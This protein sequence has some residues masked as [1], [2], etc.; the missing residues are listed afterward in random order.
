MSDVRNQTLHPSPLDFIGSLGGRWL[1]SG[2][3][4]QIVEESVEGPAFSAPETPIS[5]GNMGW[6][7]W[8][9]LNRRPTVYETVALPLS[10]TGITAPEHPLKGSRARRL[11][12]VPA[13]ASQASNHQPPFPHRH[14]RGAGKRGMAAT[15]LG[16]GRSTSLPRWP[17]SDFCLF[18]FN[19]AFAP[20]TGRYALPGE[21]AALSPES[22]G[23]MRQ[24]NGFAGIGYAPATR[25][26]GFNS[27]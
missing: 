5:R 11:C 8:S 6:S 14:A 13:L 21:R 4:A 2:R 23:R 27:R 24:V 12:R 15:T 10:Y 1:D 3:T 22:A 16:S 18:P 20:L 19:F 25:S 9:G 7:R 26:R 17:G